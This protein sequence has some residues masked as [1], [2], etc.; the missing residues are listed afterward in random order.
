MYQQV[1]SWF[2]VGATNV[3][4]AAVLVWRVTCVLYVCVYMC[5]YMCVY[6]CVYMCVYMCIYI[7]M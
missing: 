3:I 7:C 2:R 5:V 4:E 1:K 6:V